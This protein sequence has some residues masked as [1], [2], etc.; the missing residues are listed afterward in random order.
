MRC[1]CWSAVFL[2]G[3]ERA[4]VSSHRCALEIVEERPNDE[5]YEHAPANHGT[6]RS[7]DE[8]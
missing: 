1:G 7:I 3:T 6:G 2:L 8:Q 5:S 4:L